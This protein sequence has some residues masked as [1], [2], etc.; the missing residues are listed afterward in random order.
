[1]SEIFVV[2][3]LNDIVQLFWLR[4][5]VHPHARET[6]S[7]TIISEQFNLIC[8]TR[9][10]ITK[11][12]SKVV[13]KSTNEWILFAYLLALFSRV[14]HWTRMWRGLFRSMTV[15]L[16]FWKS[17]PDGENS[18]TSEYFVNK[19]RPLPASPVA[20]YTCSF[21]RKSPIAFFPDVLIAALNS[22]WRNEKRHRNN[23]WMLF[24]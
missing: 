8:W 11:I 24:H 14:L 15:L 16:I 23:K 7:W 5:T 9:H 17:C 21:N 2:E 20:L 13:N 19:L 6:F 22:K 1:M 3:F 18:F 4:V 10:T 12:S